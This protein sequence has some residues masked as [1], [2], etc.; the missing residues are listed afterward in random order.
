ME[1][2]QKDEVIEKLWYIKDR[3][4]SSCNKN[5]RQLVEKVNKIAEEQGFE[6]TIKNQQKSKIA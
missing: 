5:I 3:F 6:T 2:D 1:K 4:S